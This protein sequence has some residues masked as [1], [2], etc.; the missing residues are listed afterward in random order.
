MVF[1]GKYEPVASDNLKRL[2]RPRSIASFGGSWSKQVIRQC[3]AGG[4]S[5]EIWPVHPTQT[6][7]EGLRCYRSIEELPGVPD[8]AFIGVNRH[9]TLELVHQLS[10]IGTGGAVC[11]ASGFEEAGEAGMQQKLVDQAGPMVILGPNCYGFINYL[12]QVMIW[13]DQQAGRPVASG[14]A[15]ISQSSNI[16]VNWSMGAGGLPVGYIICVGNQAM[17]TITG[18]A[19]ALL[20]DPRI[21]AIGFY[22][23]GFTDARAFADMADHA[24]YRGK[25]L[26]AIKAGKSPG[27]QSA[28]GSHS[29]SIAGEASVSSAFLA[30]CGVGEVETPEALIEALK[31][32]H[33]GGLP[34]GN[35]LVSL[36][37]S[38]GEASLM[39]DQA[40]RHDLQHP[41][42]PSAI[43]DKLAEQLGPLVHIANPLDYHTFIW[44]DREK[45]E[46]LFTLIG[47]C[48]FDLMVLVIDIPPSPPCD[49]ASW[50]LALEAYCCAAGRTGQRCAVL[51]TMG[52]LMPAS[53][54]TRLIDH[55]IAALAG[56]DPAMQAIA[57]LARIAAKPPK[58]GWRPLA[59]R[60]I[61]GKRRMVDEYDTKCWLQTHGISVPD[62]IR[63][64]TQST[65]VE[66]AHRLGGSLV[67]KRIGLAH[68]SEHDAVRLNLA[69]DEIAE[70]FARMQDQPIGDGQSSLARPA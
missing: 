42:F 61:S 59:V 68:K 69:P 1:A 51:A 34:A 54:A 2:L 8:A 21:T 13:P 52:E 25:G 60:P 17:V 37:C 48:D 62:S 3:L 27:S 26:V 49:P 39:A 14:V 29:A 16:A 47:G 28:V 43:A 44:G 35:Q 33:C 23:E 15:I 5:G 24:R 58:A 53:W 66:A 63:V 36:S 6:H 70:A 55:K 67:L 31:I 12:D 38:G 64:D 56:L 7:I 30:Q 57:A 65:A 41:A 11:F 9:Q 22:I 19:E 4:F 45:L 40:V 18:I 20:D 10:R 46:A 50:E 32:L